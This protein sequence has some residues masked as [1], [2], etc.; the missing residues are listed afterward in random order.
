[1]AAKRE[2][3]VEPGARTL[4][5]GDTGSDVRV[6]QKALGVKVTGTYDEDTEAAVKRLQRLRGVPQQGTLGPATWPYVLAPPEVELVVQPAPG[7]AS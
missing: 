2:P 4:H 3:V 5:L 1:M 7:D 6:A